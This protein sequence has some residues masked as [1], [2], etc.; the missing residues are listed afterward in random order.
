MKKILKITGIALGVL[1]LLIAILFFAVHEQEPKGQNPAEADQ[2]ARAMMSAVNAADWDST[3][4]VQW[5]FRGDNDYTW[6]KERH[7]VR[8]EWE[9]FTVLLQTQSVTGKA[10]QK[11]KLLAGEAAK[12]AINK[13]WAAFCNDSFWLNPVVKAFDPGTT[14]TL[15]TLVDGRTGLKVK[16]ESGGVTPGDAYVWI[17]DEQNR[18]IAWKMWVQIIPIGGLEASWEGWTQLTTGAWISTKHEMLGRRIDMIQNLRSGA[19]IADI[20]LQEDPFFEMDN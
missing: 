11:G 4:W 6:D 16:Y 18:P 10:Y 15:V 3:R 13:A 19:S 1:I 9:D 14:R 8:V 17:L 5:S 12:Q 2:L 7:L 20:G